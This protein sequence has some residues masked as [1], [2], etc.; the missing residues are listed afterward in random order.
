MGRLLPIRAGPWSV[1][2]SSPKN[3][4]SGQEPGTLDR[5]RHQVDE[6]VGLERFDD[7]IVRTAFGGFDSH[8]GAA[9]GRHQ[10]HRESGSPLSQLVQQLEA[11]Q[12]GKAK[13]GQHQIKLLLPDPAQRKLRTVHRDHLQ[14]FGAQQRLDR[15]GDGRVVLDQKNPW[16]HGVAHER[17]LVAGSEAG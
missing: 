14:I 17:R 6:F 9:V 7:V 2:G 15:C 4:R 3:D 5:H 16:Q 1:A 10:D 13:V 8:L 11:A 12:P